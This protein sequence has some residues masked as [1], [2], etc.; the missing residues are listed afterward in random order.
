M[1]WALLLLGRNVTVGGRFRDGDNWTLLFIDVSGSW[2]GDI[3]IVCRD[4]WKFW[5]ILDDYT[6]RPV[7]T[8]T[9]DGAPTKST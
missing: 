6:G 9:K 2:L 7:E 3:E 4:P 1:C 8:I 5:H